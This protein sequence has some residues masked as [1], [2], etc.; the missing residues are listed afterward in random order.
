LGPFCQG[1]TSASR[2]WNSATS[3]PTMSTLEFWGLRGHGKIHGNIV[4]TPESWGIT[5]YNYL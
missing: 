1:K 2:Y 3:R 4:V 5:C